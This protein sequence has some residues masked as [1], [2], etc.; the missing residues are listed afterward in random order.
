[1]SLRYISSSTFY[2]LGHKISRTNKL[3]HS[4]TIRTSGGGVRKLKWYPSKPSAFVVASANGDINKVRFV[5]HDTGPKVRLHI[6]IPF[7]TS[8]TLFKVTFTDTLMGNVPGF[9]NAFDINADGTKVAI[10]FR[11]TVMVLT[12]GSFGKYSPTP[13]HAGVEVCMVSIRKQYT[14]IVLA[15]SFERATSGQGRLFYF[16]G[17]TGDCLC[18]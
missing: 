18:H 4:F 16:S 8:D 17:S 11:G 13:V 1:M 9:I 7:G 6:P 5:L 12:M 10:G 2:S 15:C 14:C 3:K